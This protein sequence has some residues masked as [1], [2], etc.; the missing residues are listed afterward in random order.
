MI[1]TEEIVDVI[2][3]SLSYL[4]DEGFLIQIN[5]ELMVSD[6][7]SKY[8]NGVEIII[9]TPY[10]ISTGNGTTFKLDDVKPHLFELE[11]QLVSYGVKLDQ[12]VFFDHKGYQMLINYKI[13]SGKYGLKMWNN[14]SISQVSTIKAYFI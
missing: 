5:R 3:D 10:S 6:D 7:H 13:D 12:Y 1:M 9:S 2:N 11:S 4:K 8:V 14:S